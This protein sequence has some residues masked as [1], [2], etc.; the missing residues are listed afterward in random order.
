VALLANQ[1]T[2]LYS[3]GTNITTA[4]NTILVST[5]SLADGSALA[6]TLNYSLDTD[7]GLF[8]SGDGQVSVTSNGTEVVRMTANGIELGS[9]AEFTEFTPFGD[10]VATNVQIAIEDVAVGSAA[11]L[12]AHVTDPTGAHA[13]SAISN[14]PAGDIVAT[15]VQEAIDELDADKVPRTSSIGS[16]ITPTGTTGERD[17]SP[18]IGYFRFNTTLT[19]FEGYFG[20]EWRDV[21]GGQLLGTAEVKSI[22]YA[23]QTIAENLTVA[24]GTNGLT[25]GPVTIADGFTVT[26]SDGSVWT[27]V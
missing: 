23:S 25:P 17:G 21:G 18:V 9:V 16:A 6:P 13:A 20:T 7:T 1:S 2:V 5:L 10:I 27:V 4:I 15:N 8:R 11:A 19:R 24:A 26:V 3:D 12:Q 22:F 14:T